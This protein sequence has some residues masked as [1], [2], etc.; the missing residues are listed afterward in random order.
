MAILTFAVDFMLFGGD[1][2]TLGA[3]LPL[4]AGVGFALG[5]ITYKV[6]L[7]WYGDD[8]TAASIKGLVVALLTAMPAPIPA[9][10]S[11]PTGIVGF[12]QNMRKGNR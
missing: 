12:M 6:Q 10:L 5:F 2:V 11:I 1:V 9:F 8:R 4:S 3:I 7:A